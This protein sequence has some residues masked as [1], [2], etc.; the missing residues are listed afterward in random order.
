MK[1]K[2]HI[3]I[4]AYHIIMYYVIT[5]PLYLPTNAYIFMCACVYVCMCIICK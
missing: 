2:Y 3:K 4:N 1:N 5:C